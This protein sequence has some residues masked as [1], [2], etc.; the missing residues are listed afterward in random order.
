MD[1]VFFRTQF[2]P[3][4][5]LSARP[6]SLETCIVRLQSAEQC[7]LVLTLRL[8]HTQPRVIIFGW[9]RHVLETD[10]LSLVVL[11]QIIRAL[12]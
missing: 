9:V 11:R 10:N 2:A 1:V 7:A 6:L 5:D 12:G 4:C 8:D 3:L